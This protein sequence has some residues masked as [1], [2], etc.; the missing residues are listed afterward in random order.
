[1]AVVLWNYDYF[2]GFVGP[3]DTE[4]LSY[5]VQCTEPSDCYLIEVSQMVIS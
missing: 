5:H 3:P 1:M 2:L 4:E